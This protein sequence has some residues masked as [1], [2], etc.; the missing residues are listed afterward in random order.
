M[1]EGSAEATTDKRYLDRYEVVAVALP[2]AAAILFL[3]Y[4]HPEILGTTKFELKDVSVG[5]LGIFAIAA[6]IVG[7]VVQA[8]ANLLE[9][10][11]NSLADLGARARRQAYPRMGNGSSSKPYARWV[12]RIRTRSI[13]A[14]TAK[15]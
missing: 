15:N 4:L 10:L 3:W 11:L 5:T 13:G 8:V 6:L 9:E 1:A 14:A 2:G 12:S 7:Q